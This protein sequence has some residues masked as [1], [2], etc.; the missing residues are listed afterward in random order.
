MGVDRGR[1]GRSAGAAS[2]VFR[3]WGRGGARLIKRM[4][5]GLAGLKSDLLLVLSKGSLI[6]SLAGGRKGPA[7]GGCEKRRLQ[8]KL[9]AAA[10]LTY[11]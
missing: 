10:K 5:T 8:I 1:G 3:S 11:V 4:G 7:G 9:Q 6:C 2:A